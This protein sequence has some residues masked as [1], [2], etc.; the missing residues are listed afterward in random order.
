MGHSTRFSA[1]VAAVLVAVIILPACSQ[2]GARSSSPRLPTDAELE[3]Y[4]AQVP[5]ER[6]I[7]CRMETPVDSN[8]ARRVC[9]EVRDIEEASD[10][11]QEQLRR[12]I[13]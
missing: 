12:I 5:P 13:R 3:Q 8:I 1:I 9:R 6:Q 10:F 4:N 11:H 7:V 2:T